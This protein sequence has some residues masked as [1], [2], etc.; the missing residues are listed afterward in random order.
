[1]R[2]SVDN[3][4]LGSPH[5][6]RNVEWELDNAI[7]PLLRIIGT[8]VGTRAVSDA[9]AGIEPLVADALGL[10]QTFLLGMDWNSPQRN[11][12]WESSSFGSILE[13]VAGIHGNEHTRDLVTP[14]LVEALVT[15]GKIRTSIM[16][17]T[18][19]FLATNFAYS[20][21]GRYR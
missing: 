11:L 18:R 7:L 20:C 6:Q 14:P 8:L 4:R 21:T 10:V 17:S 19:D 16:H 12:P 13:V 1:M 3:P 5:P 9:L 2:A 15:T